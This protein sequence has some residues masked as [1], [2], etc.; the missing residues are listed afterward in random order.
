LLPVGKFAD[1]D[2]I[3]T[4]FYKLGTGPSVVLIHGGAPGSCAS[5]NWKLNVEPLAAAGFTVYAFDQPG[6][7]SSGHPTDYSMEYRVA[8][9][10]AFVKALR[11]S[12]FNV[13]GNSQGAYI[14]ARLAL[15]D[16]GVR[17]VVFVSSATLSPPT[18]RRSRAI[19]KAHVRELRSYMPTEEKMRA[20]T[21]RTLVDRKLVTKELVRERYLM[22]TGKNFDAELERR[23][24]QAPREI[25]NELCKLK[26]RALVLAANNDRGVTPDQSLRLFHLIP[27]AEFHMFKQCGHWVQWDQAKRFNRIVADFLKK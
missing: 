20:M 15:C 13:I 10:K 11:L 26:A 22:S 17:R 4:F 7:G 19:L 24:T 3:R 25:I 21:I 16:R 12:S 9:A 5:V 2:G 6:F 27:N 14:A 8:H 18:S 1:V 23:K